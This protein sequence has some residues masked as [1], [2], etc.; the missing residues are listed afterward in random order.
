MEEPKLNSLE[1]MSQ[2]LGTTYVP[3]VKNEI[4]EIKNESK[5]LTQKAKTVEFKDKDYIIKGF[6]DIID[7]SAT[8]LKT[9]SDDIRIGA[10][11]AQ[12]KAM[13]EMVTAS[14]VTLKELFN[15]NKELYEQELMEANAHPE[16]KQIDEKDKKIPL[17][18]S[19]LKELMD[20]AKKEAEISNA[21][22]EITTSFT[23]DEEKKE[24]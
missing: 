9:L 4:S 3:D 12:Y 17:T 14:T 15:V 20:L 8:V 6:K 13:A 21:A 16:E 23:V 11:G 10:S 1:K 7:K 2:A 19:Q 24:D 5:E 22:N 18:S